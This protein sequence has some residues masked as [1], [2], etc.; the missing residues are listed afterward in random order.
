MTL[1]GKSRLRPIFF[2]IRFRPDLIRLAVD[3]ARRDIQ[4]KYKR[5]L[6]GLCWFVLTPLGSVGIYW[7][8]FGIIFHVSWRDPLT[9]DSVGFVLPF[10]AG[11]AFYLF[12]TDLIVSSANLFVAKRNYVKKSAFPLW[13]LWLANM[14]RAGAYW[15]V[16]IGILLVLAIAEQRLTMLGLF[17][18]APAILS[19]LLF[20]GALSLLISCLGPFIGDINEAAGLILRV[21]FYTAPVTYPVSIVPENYRVFLWFN[22]LTHVIEPMRRAIVFSSQPELPLLILFNILSFLLLGLSLWVFRRTQ[23]VVADVV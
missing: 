5:S 13:V 19:G 22:P 12:F 7:M 14:I 21:V 4:A 3:L 17:W 10:F 6:A 20:A 9:R 15:S 2:G 11:L 8:I 16:N 18:M 23:G 1:T